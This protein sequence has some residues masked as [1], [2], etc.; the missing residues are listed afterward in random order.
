[1]WVSKNHQIVKA[2]VIMDSSIRKLFIRH[3]LEMSIYE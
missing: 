1:M 3:E 2:M